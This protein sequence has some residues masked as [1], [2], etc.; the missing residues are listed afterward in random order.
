MILRAA[1]IADSIASGF[2]TPEEYRK[3]KDF[4]LAYTAEFPFEDLAFKQEP[5]LRAWNRAEGLP[6]SAAVK[7]VGD[8][9]Q[10]VSDLASRI[11]FQSGNLPKAGGPFP[12]S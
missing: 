6:D 5:V 12:L 2:V 11:N 10:T 4:V 3:G 8:L 7:T 1:Y 9:P